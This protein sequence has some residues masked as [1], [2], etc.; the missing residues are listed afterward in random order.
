MFF[1]GSPLNYPPNTL[2][3]IRR[4]EASRAPTT[5][6]IKNFEIGDE[7]LDVSS[8][9]W[10]KLVSKA[11]NSALWCV[12]CGEATQLESI[13]PDSGISPVVP[14]ASNQFIFTGSNGMTT[15]G[16]LN[17][18]TW[19][20]TGTYEGD[21]S[22]TCPSSEATWQW[23]CTSQCTSFR[24]LSSGFAGTNW[25]TCQAAVQTVDA[26]VT[27]IALIS[28]DDLRVLSVRAIFSGAR[29]DHSAAVAGEI[30]YGA[31]RSGGGALQMSAPIINVQN[32][33]TTLNPLGADVSGNDVRLLVA[34]EAATTWNWV[35]TYQY[36]ILN[37]NA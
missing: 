18:V 33:G 22:F 5:F 2:A 12:L 19:Q 21:W 16:G 3:S 32:D 14:N 13:I 23:D 20:P 8:N 28:L 35:T 17:T 27:P 26:T 9:V 31:R 25:L 6:D 29:A 1:P 30:S 34:G 36:Q 37:T 7:W 4:Y 10:Y 24:G 11:N 15:V